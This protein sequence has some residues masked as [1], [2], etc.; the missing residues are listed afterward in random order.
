MTLL[1]SLAT[2]A[3]ALFQRARGGDTD[4]GSQAG[5][6]HADQG[7]RE[8]GDL[9][10]DTAVAEG[11]RKMGILFSVRVAKESSAG[12]FPVMT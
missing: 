5:P 11:E 7:K 8:D 4:Q 12:P 6:D 10:A 2:A 1:S 3:S 9:A